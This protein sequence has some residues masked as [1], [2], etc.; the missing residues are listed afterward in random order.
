MCVI[1]EIIFFVYDDVNKICVDYCRLVLFELKELKDMYFSKIEDDYLV[2]D[3]LQE[4][5]EENKCD[6]CEIDENEWYFF[7]VVEDN[8]EILDDFFDIYLE[9]DVYEIE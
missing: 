6:V 4:Y 5:C 9:K 3:D 2:F 8:F 1:E 7:F